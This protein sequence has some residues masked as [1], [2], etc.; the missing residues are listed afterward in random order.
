MG[1]GEGRVI[2]RSCSL[3][4]TQMLDYDMMMFEAMSNEEDR[5]Y[6]EEARRFYRPYLFSYVMELDV[7]KYDA[8]REL[9]ERVAEESWWR[10][11]RS[12]PYL[13]L[14]CT[15]AQGESTDPRKA[16][17]PLPHKQTGRKSPQSRPQTR[18]CE[19]LCTRTPFVRRPAALLTVPCYS[20]RNRCRYNGR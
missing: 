9:Q 12:D 6:R 7:K 18:P 10:E 1:A 13:W 3:L 2:T 4:T 5:K 14:V 19:A 15:F 16:C 11:N 20:I 17:H 8:L